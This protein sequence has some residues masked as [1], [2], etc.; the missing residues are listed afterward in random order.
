MKLLS[1]GE[2]LVPRTELQGGLQRRHVFGI[3]DEAELLLGS[4]PQDVH[5]RGHV[6]GR[7]RARLLY[8]RDNGR[9]DDLLDIG[10]SLHDERVEL[11]HHTHSRS[12]RIP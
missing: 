2:N 8:R 11:H 3:L 1:Q 5:Q 4:A 7:H 10:P 9:D 6:A 12:A